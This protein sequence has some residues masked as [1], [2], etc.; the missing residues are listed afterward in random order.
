MDGSR[1][2]RGIFRQFLINKELGNELDRCK[3]HLFPVFI[4]H[5]NLID[6]EFFTKIF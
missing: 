1:N 4:L 6:M 2:L 5:Y 3:Y